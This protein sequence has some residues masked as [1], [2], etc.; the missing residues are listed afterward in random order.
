MSAVDLNPLRRDLPGDCRSESARD[1]RPARRRS[2]ARPGAHHF[3]WELRIDG[4]RALPQPAQGLGFGG[5]PACRPHG[6]E[7]FRG[8]DSANSFDSRVAAPAPWAGCCL[9]I[10]DSGC[11]AGALGGVISMASNDSSRVWFIT[12]AASGIGRTLAQ[13]AL[14]AGDR[15][16]A[17][18]RDVQSMRGLEH[19]HP[20]RVVVRPLDVTDAAQARDA[21]RH[22]VASFRRIDVVVSNAGVGLFGALEDLSDDQ[23]HQGF[24]TNVFGAMHTIRAALPQLRAQ[25][26]GLI[27]QISSLDGVAPAVA[28]ESAYAATKFAVEGLCEGL[29]H[30]VEHLGIR[31]TLVEPGPTRTEFGER[32]VITPPTGDHYQESVGRA[33]TWFAELAGSQPN[34]PE[35]VAAAIVA[36]A[37]DPTPPL[38]LALGVEAVNTIH[39]KLAAQARELDRWADLSRSTPVVA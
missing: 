29:R 13:R 7:S 1:R 38:R 8:R 28:G 39:D 21:V 9:W 32:A 37:D 4:F 11:G 12:G 14:S 15:V 18:C 22:A 2:R 30:D 24:E 10:C 3:V 36:I 25:R 31:V 23:L 6:R 5:K 26:S 20:G 27:V 34:D 33:L 35:R 19:R 17:T 16:V